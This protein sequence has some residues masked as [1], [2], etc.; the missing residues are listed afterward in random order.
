LAPVP[1]RWSTSSVSSERRG[2]WPSLR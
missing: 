2:A 1:V